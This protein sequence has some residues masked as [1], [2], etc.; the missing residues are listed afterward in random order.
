M[1]QHDIDS[2]QDAL[3]ILFVNVT[4]LQTLIINIGDQMEPV[5]ES[6]NSLYSTWSRD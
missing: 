4:T 3:N 5:L 1:M 6:T 2:M